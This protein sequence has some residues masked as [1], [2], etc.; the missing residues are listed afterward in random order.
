VEG[1][2]GRATVSRGGRGP[3]SQS[4]Q[5]QA[6]S[7][8]RFRFVNPEVVAAVIGAGVSF[9]TLLGTLASPDLS[10]LRLPWRTCVP[11]VNRSSPR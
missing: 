10:L 11:D 7:Y 5:R 2:H 6:A 9:L 8:I 3:N 1:R 4:L